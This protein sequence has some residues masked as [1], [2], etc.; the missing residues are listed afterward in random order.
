[1]MV[2][3]KNNN[4]INSWDLGE[5][6]KEDLEIFSYPIRLPNEG[7]SM[8]NISPFIL[9]IFKDTSIEDINTF[10]FEFDVLY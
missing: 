4:A 6:S 7:A 2:E 8:K 5:E 1:M 9:L 3:Q 10:M